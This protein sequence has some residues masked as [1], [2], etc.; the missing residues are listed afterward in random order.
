MTQFTLS[1]VPPQMLDGAEERIRAVMADTGAVMV[2]A[3]G[4]DA[5]GT[6]LPLIDCTP[7]G[8]LRDDFD[9]GPAVW[10]PSRLLDKH[11]L[12]R[13]KTDFYRLRLALSLEGPVVHIA[14]PLYIAPATSAVSA[15]AYVDPANR[16]YQS[17]LELIATNHLK[18]AGAWIDGSKARE[19][20]LEAG[21]FP[22]E[23]SVIIPVRNRERTIADAIAS[24]LE[25]CAPFDFNVIVVDNHSSDGTSAIVAGYAERDPRVVHLMPPTTGYGIGGCW[26]IA[27]HSP[28]CGRFAVQLDSD[29]L[30]SA[31]DTLARIVAKF[32]AERCAMVV[33][34]YT[35]VDFNRRILPPGLIDHREW[36]AENGPNNL[37]RVNGMGAPRAFVT[38][39]ARQLPFP[40]V[41]YGEDYAMALR[42]SRTWRIGRIFDSLYLCRRWEGN[43]DARPSREQLARFN[44]YKDRLRTLELEARIRLNR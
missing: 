37:L 27:L 4:V 42:I 31:P 12:P 23:A 18:A 3:D 36:T 11:P 33:G 28:R 41:S 20:D 39:I 35:L 40:N 9:F 24:A 6:P 34:S 5:D 2:Y 30:Y 44:S 22:V 32:R 1:A 10:F 14:E 38:A 17:E 13:T 16:A 43:S 29:D 25:Q 26:N 19:A 15:F 8:G 21:D 7:G